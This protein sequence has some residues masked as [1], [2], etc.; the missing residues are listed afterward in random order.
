MYAEVDEIGHAYPVDQL[1]IFSRVDWVDARSLSAYD[2]RG[3][4]KKGTA[5]ARLGLVCGQRVVK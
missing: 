5:G 4:M 2:E 3:R 1:K